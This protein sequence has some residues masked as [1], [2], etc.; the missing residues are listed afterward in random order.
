[1]PK[2]SGCLDHIAAM[3]HLMRSAKKSKSNIYALLL[4][5]RAAYDSVP[6]H[7]LWL[8]LQHAGASEQLVQYVKALY[9]TSTLYAQTKDFRTNLIPYGRG[10]LQGDTLSPLLFTVYFMVVIRAGQR[11]HGAGVKVKMNDGQHVHHLK[12]FADDLNV[13]DVTEAKLVESW[14]M[15]KEGLQWCGLEVNHAKCRALIFDKGQLQA[16]EGGLQL[17]ESFVVACGVKEGASFLGLNIKACMSHEEVEKILMDQLDTWLSHIASLNYSLSA[18]LFF[19]EIGVL[20]RFRWWFT[21]YENVRIGA[22]TD[23]QRKAWRAFRLWGGL[24]RAITGEVFTSARAYGIEDLRTTFRTSRSLGLFNGLKAADPITV[25]A[26]QSKVTLPPPK[27]RDLK[28]MKDVA[29]AEL[30]VD[31]KSKI[32]CEARK[33]ALKRDATKGEK[34]KGLGWIWQ[35]EPFNDETDSLAKQTLRGLPG[36]ILPSAL[37]SWCDMLPS[38]VFLGN[39]LRWDLQQKMCPLCKNKQQDLYHILNGCQKALELGRYTYRHNKV[40]RLIVERLKLAHA[41]KPH[42]LYADLDGWRAEF[43]TKIPEELKG[44]Y[45]PDILLEVNVDNGIEL[46]IIELSCPFEL[47]ANL[48]Y[49]HGMKVNKYQPFV[50]GITTTKKYS[51]VS[52]HCIEVGARGFI[53]NSCNAITQYLTCRRKVQPVHSFLRELGRASFIASMK[54]FQNRDAATL[55]PIWDD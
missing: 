20:S 29:A 21:I 1:M 27:G 36:K 10:V 45:K 42:L 3:M 6:H 17:D 46:V 5:L 41:D 25:A 26:Y 37:R 13:V 38:K 35:H 8:V 15:L 48:Q 50:E 53:A 16:Q 30:N 52:L 7:K 51:K 4:D 18:K 54:I 24:N 44:T 39:K 11:A 31:S 9:D 2:V 22:V 49:R 47:Q 32:I 55:V 23:M 34:L 12:A 19:Y 40:L 43:P 28:L 33:L 14:K